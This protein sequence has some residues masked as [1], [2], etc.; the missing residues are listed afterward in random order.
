MSTTLL[1]INPT[2]GGG[3]GRKTGIQT[4]NILKKRN[5]N[6]QEVIEEN[7][8]DA[9]KALK[10]LSSKVDVDKVILVGGDGLV[11][12][13]IQL[14]ANTDIPVLVIPAGTGNDFVRAQNFPLRN[15]SEI[16]DFSYSNS[17]K[18]V[19]LGI[20]NGE[21][22]ADILST[23]FD[24]IVNERANRISRIHGPMKYNVAIALEL[25]IFKPQRYR[26]TI[27][28]E[29]LETQ[30]MLIAVANGNSYGGGMLVC[31]SA[32][33]SDGLFDVMILS[34]ISKLEF[35][36]VFPKVF[37]GKHV[38]HPA[39]TIKRCREITIEAE[40]IAYS[41]G[42]RIGPLPVTAKIAPKSLLTWHRN[43]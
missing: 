31:P 13:G 24:A 5:V 2:S 41:D 30:A 36:K 6:F 26:F 9:R 10:L 35:I 29:I 16:I 27:D 38:T 20:V 3:R 21:Y 40:A 11:H 28:G 39:V 1:V 18:Y 33:I 22:F 15:I 7:S 23:G 32:S 19:D 42:E 17:P 37:S 43:P 25:P 4:A 14:L 34:P 8:V 12:L